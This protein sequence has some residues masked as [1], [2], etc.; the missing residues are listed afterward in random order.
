MHR[1]RWI[2]CL[3]FLCSCDS[4]EVLDNIPG[5]VTPIDPP[6]G[7]SI[8]LPSSPIEKMEA[9]PT[10]S[11][12]RWQQGE[13]YMFIHFGINT[14]TQDWWG[15]GTL[16]PD[17]FKPTQL[18]TRQ[19][20]AL[21]KEVG[22]DGMIFTARHHDGF[23]LW[24]TSTTD[25][26][27][28]NSSWENGN[29]DVVREVADAAAEFDL[30][31]GIYLSP[32]DRHEPTWGSPNYNEY[33]VTQLN[34]LLTGYGPIFEYWYDGARGDEPEP[35]YDHARW[36]QT[37]YGHHPELVIFGGPDLRWVGNEDGRAN[38]TNWSSV[39]KQRWYPAEC[40]VPNRPS[41]FWRENENDLVKPA[42]ELL[43]IYFSSVGRNCVLLLN[44]PPDTS[45]LIHPNDVAE[46]RLFKQ[47]LD[48]VFETNLAEKGNTYS[49]DTRSGKG[50]W[51]PNTVLD[52]RN[53]SFWV[54][55][56]GELSGEFEIN[57]DKPIRFNVIRLEEPIQFGQRVARFVVDSFNPS[58]DRWELV[59]E[60]TTIG[61]KRLVRT[62][63]TTTSRIRVRILDSVAAPA[64][65]EF[66]LHLDKSQR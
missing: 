35:P 51:G 58:A 59:S 1:T 56:V 49:A 9:V 41:W 2:I 3:A 33:Y 52:G 36:Y 39:E 23:A 10:E 20:A 5:G 14:Y 13:M 34:E 50:N 30:R 28:S 55:D 65:S 8:F 45:G 15:D 37:I 22:F 32:W 63:E 44:A 6:I 12:L 47:L 21:A 26:S 17:V 61:Y 43:D 66:G 62:S 16:S 38:E 11:Q 4:N 48:D 24:P 53:D 42:S 57:F 29:R 54:T 64:I 7:E 31:F 27:V 25:Y 18:D 40:D 19:W 46:F 60:G